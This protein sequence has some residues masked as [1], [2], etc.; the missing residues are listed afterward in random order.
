MASVLDA[1]AQGKVSVHIVAEQPNHKSQKQGCVRTYFSLRFM[2][3]LLCGGGG[4]EVGCNRTLKEHCSSY[5]WFAMI[6]RPGKAA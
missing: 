1:L 6:K 4:E 3:C 2:V 5:S